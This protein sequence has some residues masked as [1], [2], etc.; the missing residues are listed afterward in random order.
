MS[1][2][3]AAYQALIDVVL[4]ARTEVGI[5]QTALANKLKRPQS[6]IGKIESGARNVDV[7]EFIEIA[8]ALKIDPAKLFAKVV[9]KTGL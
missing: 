6:F 4:D 9:Q 7:I 2:S 1:S 8:R 3:N 5:T